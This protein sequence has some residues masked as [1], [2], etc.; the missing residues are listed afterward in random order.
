MEWEM[1]HRVAAV[2][3]PEW[4]EHKDEVIGSDCEAQCLSLLHTCMKRMWG[5]L[6][7]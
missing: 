6:C 2:L 1:D 7:A 3:F 5:A 4:R